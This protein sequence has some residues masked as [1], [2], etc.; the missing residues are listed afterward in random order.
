M[1]FMTR[2]PSVI[3]DGETDVLLAEVG[4]IDES[5]PGSVVSVVKFIIRT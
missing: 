3:G 4:D 1:K 5:I 2:L